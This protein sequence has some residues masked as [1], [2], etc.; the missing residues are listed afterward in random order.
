MNSA[1]SPLHSDGRTGALIHERLPWAQ[2]LHAQGELDLSVAADLHAAIESRS[3]SALPVVLDLSDCAY[4]DS[5]ILRVLVRSVR[6]M[7][8]RFGIVVPPA[9]PVRRIF[10][11][12]A[13]IGVLPIVETREELQ[14]RLAAA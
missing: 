8:D 13:L 1:E 11:V 3:D 10:D 9:A 7:P 6:K 14:D 5:T 12:A 2:V 4:L